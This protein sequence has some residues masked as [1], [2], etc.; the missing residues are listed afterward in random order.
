MRARARASRD[1]PARAPLALPALAHA[2]KMPTKVIEEV[3]E[4]V[5]PSDAAAYLSAAVTWLSVAFKA[6]DGAQGPKT[7]ARD[8]M[9]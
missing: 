2:R 9:S 8:G 1:F 5:A 3:I 4:E 7:K 6:V